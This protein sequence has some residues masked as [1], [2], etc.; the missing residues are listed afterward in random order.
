MAASLAKGAR[1]YVSVPNSQQLFVAST[2]SVDALLDLIADQ[3]QIEDLQDPESPS[4]INA[5]A[6]LTK[7]RARLENF[8]VVAT[9]SRVLPARRRQLLDDRAEPSQQVSGF[10]LKRSLVAAMPARSAGG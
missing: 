6:L 1:R 7:I 4:S 8:V 2:V 5:E 3:L 10:G 9:T